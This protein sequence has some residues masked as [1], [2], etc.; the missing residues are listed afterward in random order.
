LELIDR[1]GADALRFTVASMAASSAGRLRLSPA[2]VE[3]SRNFATKLWNATRF[4]EVNGAALP[5]GFDP[6]TAKLTVNRWVLGELAPASPATGP[7]A[8]DETGWLV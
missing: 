2:R 1:Y 4:A 5:K 6:A 8:D 7:G 3:G